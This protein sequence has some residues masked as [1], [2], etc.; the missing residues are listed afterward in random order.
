MVGLLGC[1]CCG[2]GGGDEPPPYYGLC[3]CGA[4]TEVVRSDYLQQ[5]NQPIPSL[6]IFKTPGNATVPE[7]EFIHSGR[8]Y[9]APETTTWKNGDSVHPSLYS[10]FNNAFPWQNNLPV[11]FGSLPGSIFGVGD[12]SAKRG[13]VSFFKVQYCWNTHNY[14]LSL[15][16][17]FNSAIKPVYV[18]SQA[19]GGVIT[20]KSTASFQ[21]GL[22]MYATDAALPYDSFV[23]F[24][25]ETEYLA[26]APNVLYPAIS[27]RIV[28]WNNLNYPTGPGRWKILDYDREYTLT[29]LLSCPAVEYP[30]HTTISVIVKIDDEPLAT[31]SLPTNQSVGG[32]PVSSWTRCTPTGAADI[33]RLL[34]CTG[35]TWIHGAIDKY[36]YY[37][38]NPALHAWTDDWSFNS[39]PKQ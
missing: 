7:S 36:S 24:V 11:G 6:P 25:Q 39:T 10:G 4:Q 1:G 33:W 19:A 23:G 16:F 2:G 21:V 5:W 9:I 18:Q 32:T 28:V 17:K 15:K 22:S 12:L 34:T 31:Y 20:R 30:D 26:F 13:D 37:P 29:F 38:D 27:S 14:E 35:F 8:F 3:D